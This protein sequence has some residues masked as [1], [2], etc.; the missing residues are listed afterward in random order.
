MCLLPSRLSRLGPKHLNFVLQTLMSIV[1]VLLLVSQPASGQMKAQKRTITFNAVTGTAN[2]IQFNGHSYVD[3]ESL[4]RIGK[5]SVGFRGERIVLTFPPPATAQPAGLSR[6]FSKAGIEQLG[7]AREW[8]TTVSFAIQNGYQLAGTWVNDYT[9]R[10]A[11][12]LRV[13]S[14]SAAT[15]EDRRAMQLLQSQFNSLQAWSNSMVAARNALNAQLAISPSTVTDDPAYQ[16]LGACAQFLSS[17]LVSGY[18][19][20]SAI[21]H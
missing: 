11:E 9:T 19:E 3:L 21:C 15:P 18:F 1:A 6:E 16:K 8:M 2:V 12:R 10:T 5:G 17:M 4:A 14:V 13:A 20:D 7:A